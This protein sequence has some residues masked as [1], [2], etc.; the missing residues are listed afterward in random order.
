MVGMSAP[1]LVCKQNFVY[2]QMLACNKP[3][4]NLI[5]LRWREATTQNTSAFMVFYQSMFSVKIH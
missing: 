3:K 4:S 2:I 5:L 1:G